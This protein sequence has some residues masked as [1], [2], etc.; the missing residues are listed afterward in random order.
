M[1]SAAVGTKPAA[2]TSC[3]AAVLNRTLHWSNAEHRGRISPHLIK[4]LRQIAFAYPI[5]LFGHLGR[6]FP[7]GHAAGHRV[8]EDLGEATVTNLLQRRQNGHEI[9]LAATG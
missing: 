8:H 6:A 3:W 2:S 1:T 9:Q 7:D 4:A 5:Y